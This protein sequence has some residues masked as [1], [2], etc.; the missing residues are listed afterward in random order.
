MDDT[1]DEHL[2]GLLGSIT[3]LERRTGVRVEA[4]IITWRGMMT[5]VCAEVWMG[6]AG[7][8]GERSLTAPG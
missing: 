3:E 7:S 6:G 1:K 4:D 2:D 8:Q 5:K